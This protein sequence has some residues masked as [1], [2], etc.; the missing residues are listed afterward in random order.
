LRCSTAVA[1]AQQVA[2]DSLAHRCGRLENEM[3]RWKWST[4]NVG[5]RDAAAVSALDP[6]T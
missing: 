2:D 4:A 3:I 1:A 6:P 5:V